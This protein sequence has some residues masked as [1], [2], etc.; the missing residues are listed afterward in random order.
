MPHAIHTIGLSKIFGGAIAVDNLDL[1]IEA[2]SITAL[3]GGNGAGK[4]TTMAM[5]LG[6]LQPTSGS[7][8]IFGRD[9][10]KERSAIAAAVNFSSPYVDLPNRLTVRQNLI[11]YGHLYG[12]P[13]LKQR[14]EELAAQLMLEEILDRHHGSLSAGQKTRSSL[15]KSLL[16]KPRLLLLDEPTASLDPDTAD[17]VRALLMDYRHR[18]GATIF[19]ASHNMSEVE[20]MADSVIVMKTGRIVAHDTPAALL[21]S[22]S[23]LNLE[24]VF[25]DIARD[26][27]THGMP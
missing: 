8:A 26:R 3:L 19:M 22:Y 1:A 25:L 21:A 15:A 2:G 12:V 9:L 17:W 5:L 4:S 6:L 11:V 16:N 27:N 20:R 13:D 18:T 14:I 10:L 7:I 24:E 23:R